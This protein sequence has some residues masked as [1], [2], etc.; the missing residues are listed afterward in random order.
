MILLVILLIAD[1]YILCQTGKKKVFSN[2]VSQWTVYGT[3]TCEWTRKQLDYLNKTKRPYN[4]I[5]CNE[6]MCDDVTSYPT[7]IHPNGERT[8]G[9]S[10][11]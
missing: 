10:E 4:F 11:F 9:Y 6:N 3:M 1:I 8:V 5:N 2:K 7:I